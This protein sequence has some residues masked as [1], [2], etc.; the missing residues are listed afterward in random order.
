MVK[1]KKTG[2]ILIEAGLVRPEQVEAALELRGRTLLLGM[3]HL[4]D[5][6]AVD[7]FEFRNNIYIE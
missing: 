1:K 3:A 7:E 4:L 2:E 5:A 6:Q